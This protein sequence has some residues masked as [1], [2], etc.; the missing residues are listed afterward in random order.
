M[1][2]GLGEAYEKLDRLQEAKKCFWKA[3]RVGDIEGAALLK[4]AK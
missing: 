4:L 2:M 1:I 3:H